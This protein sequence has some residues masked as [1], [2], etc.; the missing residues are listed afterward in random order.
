M[1]ELNIIGG[2]KNRTIKDSMTL[3]DLV[4]YIRNPDVSHQ[5]KVELARACGKGSQKYEYIKKNEIPCAIL[6]FTHSKGYVSGSTVH[7]PTGYLYLDVDNTLDINLT[8]PHITAY[9]KSLSGTGYSIVVAVKGLT[10]R[11]IKAAT[12][13]VAEALDLPFDPAAISLDRLTCISYDPNAY[14]N[15][16]AEVYHIKSE[17]NKK[18]QTSVKNSNS[19]MVLGQDCTFRKIRVNNLTDVIG[20]LDFNGEP[21]YDFG[22]AGIWYA[23]VHYSIRGVQEG[24]RNRVMYYTVRQLRSLNH[25]C[26]EERMYQYV[27]GLNRNAFK[28]PLPESELRVIVE[29]AYKGKTPK[30]VHNKW[31]RFVYNPDYDLTNKQKRS[32]VITQINRDISNNNTE[33]IL[34][35]IQTWNF[36]EHGKITIERL[37]KLSGLSVRAIKYRSEVLKEK[38]KK[39]N[40]DHKKNNY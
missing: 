2:I 38:I 20:A 8:D 40:L 17:D 11:N 9:W 15:P 37:S 10:K 27:R 18:V 39:K 22:S 26:S 13:E 12:K 33:K 4:R 30:P 7:K 6:N 28:P 16:N 19:T 21:T 24:N 14:F 1:T 36:K 34:D 29:N 5:E 25:W 31:R 23:D 3:E 32:L 35:I